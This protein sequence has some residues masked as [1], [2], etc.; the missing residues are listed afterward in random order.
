MAFQQRSFYLALRNSDRMAD[1]IQKFLRKIPEWQKR[2]LERLIEA[3]LNG[4]TIG[5]DIKKLKNSK[6]I[7]RARKGDMR[8]IYRVA[9]KEIIIIA[10][11]RRSDTTYN[12]F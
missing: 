4:E 10:I 5:L 11:E 9:K 2:Q 8:V 1:H 7:Y 3:L 6:N 12:K